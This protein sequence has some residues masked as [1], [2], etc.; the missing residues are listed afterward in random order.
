M[1]WSKALRRS[2][3]TAGTTPA[4]ATRPQLSLSGACWFDLAGRPGL[5]IARWGRR[6]GWHEELGGECLEQGARAQRQQTRPCRARRAPTL[7]CDHRARR[8]R[9]CAATACDRTTI[10][11]TRTVILTRTAPRTRTTPIRAAAALA[12]ARAVGRPAAAA[13]AAAASRAPTPTS[14]LRATTTTMERSTRHVGNSPR[15]KRS[16]AL[17]HWPE[18]CQHAPLRR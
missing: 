16:A 17:V 7:L 6:R 10:G 13:A 18:D 5:D 15:S 9:C 11:S 12:A 2:R 3:A 4:D 14:I 8:T 1:S